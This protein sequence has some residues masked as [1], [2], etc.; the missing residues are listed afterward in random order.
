MNR[1]CAL[2]GVSRQAFYKRND[3]ILFRK[4]TIEMFVVHFVLEIRE[5]DPL[6]GADKLWRI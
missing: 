4:L 2:A 6:I 3:D 5:K 1:L